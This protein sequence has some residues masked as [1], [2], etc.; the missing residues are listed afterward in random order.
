MARLSSKDP[1]D[2]FRWSVSIDGFTKLGF[3]YCD[4]P[5]YVIN[6]KSYAEGGS[7]LVPK[8]I[9]DSVEFKP[10]TFSRGV[11]IDRSFNEWAKLAF[12]FTHGD[13]GNVGIA[14]MTPTAENYRRDVIIEHLDRVGRVHRTYVIYNAFPIEYEPASP[15][16]ADADDA[17]SIEKLVLAYEG[18]TVQVANEETNSFDTGSIVKRL[19]RKF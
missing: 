2:R 3:Y 16:Q 9:I 14:G 1:L 18:F 8:K 5:S 10:V 11:T 13:G 15:F 12:K 17:V 7:H 6:T 4:T 19:I